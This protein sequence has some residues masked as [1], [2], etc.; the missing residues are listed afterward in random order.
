MADIL[1]F[2]VKDDSLK[3][4]LSNNPYYIDV[5]GSVNICLIRCGQE[6]DKCKSVNFNTMT[7]YGKILVLNH[8]E[9]T[10]GTCNIKLA[11]DTNN[12][13]KDDKG[14][15]L[16]KFTKA[17]FTVPSLHRLNGAI[18]DMETFLVFS[19]VQKTGDILYIVLC[20]LS[21][22]TTSIQPTDPN[23]L[24]YKLMNELF[25][26]DNKIPEI[27]GTNQIQGKP[28]PVDLSSFLPREG[29]RNFYDYTHPQNNKVNF[30]VFQT[31]LSISNELLTE[32]K[33][34]LTPG[35]TYENF[36]NAILKTINPYEGLFFYFSEDFTSRYKS[37]KKNSQKEQFDN[38][39]DQLSDKILEDQK[40][41]EEEQENKDDDDDLFKKIDI[42]ENNSFE[43][44]EED[45][46]KK[47]EKFVDVTKFPKTIDKYQNITII[48]CAI[49]CV[50]LYNVINYIF[51]DNF[52]QSKKKISDEYIVDNYN[53]ELLTKL[54]SNILSTKYKLSFSIYLFGFFTIICFFLSFIYLSSSDE[55][56]SIPY[57]GMV[58]VI[59]VMIVISFY[60]LVCW[61]KYI[62]Y[63]I[64]SLH[65]D[66]FT[67]KE[68]YFFRSTFKSLLKFDNIGK[69][70]MGIFN[71]DFTNFNININNIID[72][73][74]PPSTFMKGGNKEFHRDKID[75][76]KERL[77]ADPDNNSDLIDRNRLDHH[78]EMYLFDNDDLSYSSRGSL[79]GASSASSTGSL[80]GPSTGF[81]TG[82]LTGPSSSD[83]SKN[84]KEINKHNAKN[85]NNYKNKYITEPRLLLPAPGKDISDDN[86]YRI[87]K[88]AENKKAFDEMNLNNL[89]NDKNIE[90]IANKFADNPG[91]KK[92]LIIYIIFIILSF[93]LFVGLFQFK[94]LFKNEP[95]CLLN[96]LTNIVININIY[97]PL[98][99]IFTFIGC[100]FS[101]IGNPS[102]T[103]VILVL[104]IAALAI[105]WI[106]ATLPCST[107]DPIIFFYI[108]V[109]ILSC[110]IL[111][112][113]YSI[114]NNKIN[115]ET[116]LTSGGGPSI[117]GLSTAASGTASGVASGIASGT[118]GLG[119]GNGHTNSSE[120]GIISAENYLILR[121]KYYA[122]KEKRILAE[123]QLHGGNNYDLLM[124]ELDH[125]REEIERLAVAL[126]AAVAAAVAPAGA[127]AGA[128]G[129]PAVVPAV[130][131]AGPLAVAPAVVAPAVAAHAAEINRVI[132]N[133]EGLI[134]Q[135]DPGVAEIRR[136]LDEVRVL[137]PGAA[138]VGRRLNVSREFDAVL[139]EANH[140]IGR[141]RDQ[142]TNLRERIVNQNA[143][144]QNRNI[145]IARKDQNLNNLQQEIRGRNNRIQRLEH[146]LIDR[147][148]QISQRSNNLNALQRGIQNRNTELGVLRNHMAHKD[149]II[150]DLTTALNE[151]Q[152]KNYDCIR[153]IEELRIHEN[154]LRRQLE[155]YEDELQRCIESKQNDHVH[156]NNLE[157]EIARI[158]EQ[159]L[160]CQ[161]QR[162]E[163]ESTHQTQNRRIEE[164]EAQIDNRN[165]QL[166]NLQGEIG[167]KDMQIA[168]LGQG[169]DNRNRHIADLQG[170]LQNRAGGLAHLEGEI[171]EKDG[172]INNLT[173]G[174]D[175]LRN[176]ITHK[177]ETI[178]QLRTTLNEFQQRNIDCRRDIEDLT[179]REN[180]TRRRLAEREGELQRYIES[181]QNN[182]THINNLEA[183]I[184][185]LREQLLRYQNQRIELETRHQQQNTYIQDLEAE[186]DNRNRR[187]GNLERRII[188]RDLT[189]AQLRT[190]LNYFQQRNNNCR[191]V[192]DDLTRRENDIRIRLTEREG[193]LQRCIESKHA[194][195]ET[196]DNLEGEIARLHD[197]L[198]QYQTERTELETTHQLQNRRIQEL[199]IEIDNRNGR[200]DN[201][202]DRIRDLE[203]RLIQSQQRH[204]AN[205]ANMRNLRNNEA[206]LTRR[207][208][209]CENRL[210]LQMQ[211]KQ[212]NNRAINNLQ[213]ERERLSEALNACKAQITQLL[214]E[215]QQQDI[216][217]DHL[218]DQ[219]QN[220]KQESN[221]KNTSIQELKTSLRNAASTKI[222]NNQTILDLE[223]LIESLNAE[224]QRLTGEKIEFENQ[225]QNLQVELAETEQELG[226]L[227]Q[228][229]DNLLH[230][231]DRVNQQLQ[232]VTRGRDQLQLEKEECEDKLSEREL[233]IHELE[234]RIQIMSDQ[235]INFEEKLVRQRAEIDELQYT[236]EEV[237]RERENLKLEIEDF[238]KELSNLYK[239]IQD[240]RIETIK[241]KTIIRLLSCMKDFIKRTLTIKQ[242]A[243]D[244][245]RRYSEILQNTNLAGHIE[246]TRR[247]LRLN[248]NNPS[249]EIILNLI[250]RFDRIIGQ[251]HEFN[252]IAGVDNNLQQSAGGLDGAVPRSVDRSGGVVGGAVTP[253]LIKT[254]RSK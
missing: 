39:Y 7:N 209:D 95:L 135:N 193:E 182:I 136:L 53:H 254:K 141:L 194:N 131:P 175:I 33:S 69:K 246:Q 50:F 214:S 234:N 236:L 157:N 87:K 171:I 142:I 203:R 147:N 202:E 205:E 232:R 67:F 75:Y 252:G 4:I 26:N 158:R 127:P 102:L 213:T 231:L 224:N 112:S 242:N 132:N 250:E 192:I 65:D 86:N 161:N 11:F 60:I 126:D 36:K 37:L 228:D 98:L 145:E 183:D 56:S 44:I 165:R 79:M 6:I 151:M 233:A 51:L 179:R 223:R 45:E 96:T 229:H 167:Q 240:L 211:R 143:M 16:Y 138:R 3:N 54:M 57:K 107:V 176:R 124:R 195:R 140:I 150:Q 210:E 9:K 226:G 187:L 78:K 43:K 15:A 235:K 40:N 139:Q 146:N 28:N 212:T 73:S 170:N 111:L 216:Y 197:Q 251:I 169:L 89:F 97:K 207:L 83:S 61:G 19:S 105:S 71:N 77:V 188:N 116:V 52:F 166:G 32:L 154:E 35:T 94:A 63:R 48:I 29:S 42:P 64:T 27:F 227:R 85:Y 5:K 244:A 156:I 81:S 174:I 106:T 31:P 62:F 110:I 108:F 119:V 208:E 101:K 177:D 130:A 123:S 13:N 237:I 238:K 137:G 25:M 172:Q 55:M 206:N 200:I 129:A 84:K 113:V 47:S 220:L 99:I 191:R 38:E 120:N 21:N 104:C 22:A 199:E 41:Y 109:G 184:A 30:R 221:R 118:G 144:I 23:L 125:A 149:E 82:S 114:R 80:T 88:N 134:G 133:I 76:Y 219:I 247:Q 215:Q 49:F 225:L 128:L 58:G 173:H 253:L 93:I 204:D 17:F 72:E 239:I 66:S 122:E 100:F 185:I 10:M 24:N 180:Y 34:K 248:R 230:H 245:L 148:V 218:R 121:D 155:E 181:K 162:T 70:L 2:Q 196:M 12:D 68:H 163:L 14:N 46:A 117:A 241:D 18:F 189:I 91:W 92:N 159:L 243:S 168:G 198:L 249:Y 178:E 190:T 201:L 20:V 115:Y 90:L 103:K 74:G 217:I 186:I 8:D 1:D 153:D 164:L 59:S 152:N 160:Q 222:Q